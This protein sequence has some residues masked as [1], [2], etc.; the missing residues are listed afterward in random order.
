[1][2]YF[3]FAVGYDMRMYASE[4]YAVRHV[5][6]GGLCL[7]FGDLDYHT[8]VTP[9]AVGDGLVVDQYGHLGSQH[10]EVPL[11]TQH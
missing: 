5:L 7:R 10:R 9:M 11:T 2:R 3:R 4:D 6:W 1:V 8:T